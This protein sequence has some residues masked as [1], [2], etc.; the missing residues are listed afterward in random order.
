MIIECR[1]SCHL[2]AL[3]EMGVPNHEWIDFAFDING[4]IAMKAC[5]DE[6]NPEV[7]DMT[8]LYM[9][10]QDGIFIIDIKYTEMLAMWKKHFF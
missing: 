10:G 4:V 9:V 7:Q 1:L 2:T 5:L 3:T 8:V 6:D